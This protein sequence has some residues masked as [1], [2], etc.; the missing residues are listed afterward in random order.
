MN[1]GMGLSGCFGTNVRGWK[2]GVSVRWIG[3]LERVYQRQLHGGV[4]HTHTH[5]HTHTH[6]FNGVQKT[7]FADV[8]RP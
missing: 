8:A 4:G 5:T 3:R 1:G 7:T 2:T 6:I